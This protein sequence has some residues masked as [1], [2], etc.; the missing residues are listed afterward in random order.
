MSGWVRRVS[1]GG[2]LG[3]VIVA[4][5]CGQRAPRTRVLLEVRA[6]GPLRDQVRCVRVALWGREG[7]DAGG[8]E[9][10]RPLVRTVEVE[11]WPV[12][13]WLQPL[14]GEA[15]R[16]FRVEVRGYESAP[17]EAELGALVLARAVSGWVWGERRMLRM[18][19]REGCAGRAACEADPEEDG[20]PEAC[21]TSE[22]GPEALPTLDEVLDAGEPEPEGCIDDASCDDGVE[23]T[24][25]RCVEGTCV[26]DPSVGACDGGLYCDRMRGC[27]QCLSD[28]HCDM[29]GDECSRSWCD[30]GVCRTNVL[31][32]GARCMDDGLSG[33]RDACLGGR[34]THYLSFRDV[35]GGESHTCAIDEAGALWCWG[36]NGNGQ[37]GRGPDSS[38]RL[39]GP[40]S[41]RGGVQVEM[42][43]AG[44]DFG[45]AFGSG[46]QLWCW[47]ANGNGQLGLGHRN[48]SVAEPGTVRGT[49]LEMDVKAVSVGGWHA[50][51]I[52][53]SGSL[54]CWGANG[55][56]QLGFGSASRPRSTPGVV[57]EAAL[58]G[59]VVAVSA[60]AS[61]TCAIDS[62]EGLWCW[63]NRASGRL[64]TGV[65]GS[66]GEPSPRRVMG[67]SGVQGVSA[68][69]GGHTCAIDGVGDVW[70]WG[71]N[72]RG[73]LGLGRPDDGGTP[74]VQAL[75]PQRVTGPS[76]VQTVAAGR[77]H[78][79]AIDGVGGVWCWGANDRGQL[80]L[81]DRSDRDE[82]E[83]VE[84]LSGV[85]RLTAGYFH[86][87]AI[88][89][90]GALWCWGA[91]GVGQLGIEDGI[92]S[93]TPQRVGEP[94]PS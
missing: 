82:P 3:F 59:G 93:D 20:C 30:E 23:C 28:E 39:P 63:G 25:D 48:S 4:A 72:D 77:E 47:G 52:D 22:E 33:T 8:A 37:L 2:W 11:R 40:V 67:P 1:F 94:G 50:C 7:G 14:D 35:A 53:K 29:G 90:A 36:A 87:C 92:G 80:G 81:G 19:L 10:G 34:C 68:G 66:G 18:W 79:C 5:A 86:T 91:N 38:S 41:W 49:S 24:V 60:G 85:R 32:D 43:A 88:D 21:R 12:R 61:H 46:G 13:G 42:L 57:D 78:T 69:R 71:A 76:G 26:H 31:P 51:A 74:V 65:A 44:K 75:V 58:Q 9:W 6:E 83:R 70:C 55:V 27:V 17:C 62:G 73:Q 15:S 16:R 56:G 54:W 89:E 64:G 84:G 45:C